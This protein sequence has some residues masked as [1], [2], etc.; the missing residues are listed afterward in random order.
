MRTAG[1]R[2]ALA[3]KFEFRRRLTVARYFM[4]F[5]ATYSTPTAHLEMPAKDRL[6]RLQPQLFDN[7]R[8]LFESLIR[9]PRKVGRICRSA[10]CC[11]RDSDGQTGVASRRGSR[12]ARSP[13]LATPTTTSAAKIGID[14]ICSISLARS[15]RGKANGR[16]SNYTYI[17]A[18][19]TY[20]TPELVCPCPPNLTYWLEC[21]GARLVRDDF[22]ASDASRRVSK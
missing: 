17:A 6:S 18:A 7:K 15:L 16:M 5:K 2:G 4:H 1:P 10:L 12:L 20:F 14:F 19:L 3:L 8:F 13:S 11:P 21:V 22:M 9:H